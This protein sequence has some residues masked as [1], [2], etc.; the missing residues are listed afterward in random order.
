MVKLNQCDFTK[1]G[2]VATNRSKVIFHN[3]LFIFLTVLWLS[4]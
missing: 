2:L 1:V 4:C 3:C